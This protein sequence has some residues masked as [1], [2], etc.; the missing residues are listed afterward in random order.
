MK[1]IPTFDDRILC[2]FGLHDWYYGCFAVPVYGRYER[3][4]RCCDKKQYYS[5][6]KIGK[7]NI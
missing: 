7:I 4:C 3:H 5:F 2:F 6:E 1:Y